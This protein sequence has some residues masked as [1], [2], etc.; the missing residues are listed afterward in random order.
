MANDSVGIIF[1]LVQE[2]V[3][4]R[5]CNLVDVLLN[6]VGCHTYTTISNGNGLGILVNADG[7]LQ[8]T[9]FAFELSFAA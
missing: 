1:V 6:L 2:V 3:C 9:Q 4:T 7:N 8:V 5:K